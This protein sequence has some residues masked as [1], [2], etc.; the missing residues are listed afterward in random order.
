M[1]S[2]FLGLD[3][4]ETTVTLV[5][6]PVRQSGWCRASFSCASCKGA[7]KQQSITRVAPAIAVKVLPAE[8]P[9]K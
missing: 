8:Q 9:K 6:A 2:A 1:K 7:V 5:T 4:E 3:Q